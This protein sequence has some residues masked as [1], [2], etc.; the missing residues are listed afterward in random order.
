MACRPVHDLGMRHR[1]S[2][3][4]LLAALALV[5]AAPAAAWGAAPRTARTPTTLAR[6]WGKVQGIAR[7]GQLDAGEVNGA[8]PVVV[9]VGCTS[10]GACT[11]AGNYASATGSRPFVATERGG[12]WGDAIELRGMSAYTSHGEAEALAISCAR[13]GACV[14]GGFVTL[15]SGAERAVVADEVGGR[16]QAVHTLTPPSGSPR[17]SAVTAVSCPAPGDCTAVGAAGSA[18]VT[19]LAGG[20]QQVFAVEE[21][22]GA[23]GR[24]HVLPGSARLNGGDFAQVDAVS[25]AAPGSCA[26]GGNVATHGGALVPFVSVERAGHWA[27]A[28]VVPGYRHLGPTGNDGIVDAVSCAPSGCTAVGWFALKGAFTRA[29]GAEESGG[30]WHDASVIANARPRGG[31]DEA[32]SV[33][34]P[35]S[36]ACSTVGT[37]AASALDSTAFLVT[38]RAGAWGH[39]R[40]LP[41]TTRLGGANVAG[42]TSVACA[43]TTTCVAVGYVTGVSGSQQPFV[44]QQ[45]GGTWQP[46]EIAPRSERLNTGGDAGFTAAS[47]SPQGYCV[48]VGTY[49]TARNARVPMLDA[50]FA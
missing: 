27:Q 39:S 28:E 1:P 14:I 23:W 19:G 41:R 17:D 16:W 15:A 18:P 32:A 33:A 26:T 22:A 25:C 48:A 2:F 9:G 29:F 31:F 34:C 36:S 40:A 21:R 47:C 10:V 49:A 43:S 45:V 6:G 8:A 11:L 37:A 3:L 13:T 4:A 24:A 12:R 5:A 46:A 30:T 38:A 44:D 50:F 35:S 42:A 20:H 7:W